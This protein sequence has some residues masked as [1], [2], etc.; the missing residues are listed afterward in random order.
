MAELF[1]K[2]GFH[3]L[4]SGFKI[5]VVGDFLDELLV[6]DD[7]VGADDEHG[8]AEEAEFLDGDAIGRTEGK[9]A[10]I[11]EGFD[12]IDPGGPAPAGL[13]EGE[14]AAD[15]QDA[16]VVGKLGGFGIET[17]MTSTLPL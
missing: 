13:G 12:G 16:D 5:D 7:A 6:G 17:L 10:V 15:G 2:A 11:G 4:K 9:V 3:G 14:V 8:A 1:F